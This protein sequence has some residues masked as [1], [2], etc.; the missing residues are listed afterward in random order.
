MSNLYDTDFY[1]WAQRQAWLLKN[2][3]WDL[4]DTDNLIEEIESLSRHEE[5]LL[6]DRLEVLLLYLLLWQY[7]PQERR[8]S[9]DCTIFKLRQEISG[10]L[11]DSPSLKA[12]LPEAIAKVYERAKKTLGCEPNLNHNLVPQLCPYLPDQILDENFLPGSTTPN[13][14]DDSEYDLW[15]ETQVT[16]LRSE[17]WVE[18]D[19]QNLIEDL[20]N[21]HKVSL[22]KLCRHVADLLW[23]LLKWQYQE[24]HRQ[25]W[26]LISISYNRKLVQEVLQSRPSLKLQLAEIVQQLYLEVRV[27]AAKEAQINLEEF[28][29]ECPYS[30]DEILSLDF[31]PEP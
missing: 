3:A 25:D 5:G 21:A 28:P 18:L 26:W 27:R 8:R 29:V 10:L 23:Y 13:V 31:I 22:S 19:I 16:N 20:T 15:L 11:E 12:Y 7:R 17:N 9:R 2:Q 4:L 14:V 24:L 1:A 30:L 6:E